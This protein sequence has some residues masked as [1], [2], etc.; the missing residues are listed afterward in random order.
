MAGLLWLLLLL[1]LGF[2]S[3]GFAAEKSGTL[4]H[5]VAFK[6]KPDASSDQ[7]AKVVAEFRALKDKIPQIVAFET[8][9][10][11]SPEGLDKGFTHAFVLTF[12]TAA[13]R[14]AYLVHPDHQSFGKLVAPVLA[15]VFVIDFWAD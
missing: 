13:D 2:P 6:F 8:G 4:R 5:V 14:D 7:V 10:N 9:T 12:R 3:P 15:D 1:G 11:V